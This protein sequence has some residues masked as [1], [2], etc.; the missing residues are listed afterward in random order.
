MPNNLK[1]AAAKL[2]K[3]VEE[4]ADHEL[5]GFKWLVFNREVVA[6]ALGVT[7]KT[8]GRVIK[9]PVFHHITRNIEI[10]GKPK[11]AILLKLGAELCETD[12]VFKLRAIWAKGL[13]AFNNMLATDLTMKV[14]FFKQ[15]GMDKK[16]Y[17]RL[18]ARIAAAEEGGK[19]LAKLKAGEKVSLWVPRSHMGQLRGV[20]QKLGDDAFNVAAHLVTF[21]GWTRFASYLKTAGRNERHYHFPFPGAIKDNPDIALQ[22]Y[23][24]MLQEA[25]Q[26]D[27]EESAQLLA[28]IELLKPKSAD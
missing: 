18:M 9:N 15:A 12:H 13:I 11:K 27:P 16:F 4:H 24:D 8:I 28:K 20:Y 1:G 19:D 25:G 3:L 10:D 21:D 23:L 17:E 22:T 2:A 7:E 14:M 6:K 5:E 26:I